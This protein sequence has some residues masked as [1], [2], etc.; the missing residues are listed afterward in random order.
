MR[1]F[2]PTGGPEAVERVSGWKPEG[3]AE[4]GFIHLINSGAAALDATGA[5][6]DENGNGMIKRWWGVTDEDIDA[7]LG[8]QTGAV[9]I[10]AISEAADI[11]LISE[12][13]PKCQ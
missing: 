9:Q 4:N 12:L 13:L 3:L 11:L 6:K 1:T 5:C 8:L 7:M 10:L 2:A